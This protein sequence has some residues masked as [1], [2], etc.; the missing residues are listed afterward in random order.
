MKI[1]FIFAFLGVLCSKPLSHS[2]D[3]AVSPNL[4]KNEHLPVSMQADTFIGDQIIV[5]VVGYKA[6]VFLRYFGDK[7][8]DVCPNTFLLKNG[9]VVHSRSVDLSR[10]PNAG[11]ERYRIRNMAKG[12]LFYELYGD[13]VIYHGDTL[14]GRPLPFLI[15]YYDSTY[16]KL[17]HTFDIREDNPN[18]KD[19]NP[20]IEI[21]EF[22]DAEIGFA[23]G[24]DSSDVKKYWTSTGRQ[25]FENGFVDIS[26]QLQHRNKNNALI[27]ITTDLV[28]LN[29]EG[30]VIF[31]E[32]GLGFEA[33]PAL[34]TRDGRYFVVQYGALTD[35]QHYP[36]KLQNQGFRIYDLT[37]GEIIYEEQ[38]KTPLGY[39]HAVIEDAGSTLLKASK[40]DNIYNDSE[41]TVQLMDLNK[42]KIFTRKFSKEEWMEVTFRWQ[43]EGWNSY[44]HLLKNYQ[45]E[46]RSF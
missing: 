41:N 18:T 32:R 39:Y 8:L 27:K 28:V 45:F 6:P 3:E 11:K 33:N 30:K 10:T 25:F 34:V 43:R 19:K 4:E 12:I 26:Y 36:N 16:C 35:I 31:R 40:R 1:I 29:S 24:E 21:E 17:L 38:A 9:Q 23:K 20:S 5:N 42:K 2:K 22:Y 37:S 7:R 14:M 13:E 44:E 15:E 46:S